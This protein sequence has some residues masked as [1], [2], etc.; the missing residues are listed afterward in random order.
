MVKNSVKKQLIFLAFFCVAS[1]AGNPALI[2]EDSL[3]DFIDRCAKDEDEKIEFRGYYSNFLEKQAKS[4]RDS[5]RSHLRRLRSSALKNLERHH[6]QWYKQ[7]EPFVLDLAESHA[8]TRN[9]RLFLT[10]FALL[11]EYREL[12]LKPKEGVWHTTKL[13]LKSFGSKVAT[14]KDRVL[15]R[16]EVTA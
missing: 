11:E 6:P 9:I 7:V 4:R 3:D 13:Y 5:K 2:F 16:K 12:Q 14:L 15:G 8:D 10:R 1:L